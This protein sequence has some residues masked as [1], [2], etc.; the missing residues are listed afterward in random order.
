MTRLAVE[1][2]PPHLSIRT[3]DAAG[4][5][6]GEGEFVMYWMRT[7][8]RG[9][10]NP[11]LDVALEAARRLGLPV[12][13][14][15]ALSERYPYASDRHHRFILAGARDVQAEMAERGIGYAFHL[16]R[17]G[18]RGPH[19]LTLAAR[20]AL[21]VTE[22]MPVAPLRDW[23]EK[24]AEYDPVWAVDAA[25]LAPMRQVEAKATLRAFK[26][27]KASEGMRREWLRAPWPDARPG[28]PAFVPD[29]LPFEPLDLQPGGA[30]GDLAALIATCD[31]DH[32][33]GPVPH[34]PGGSAAGY[35]RWEAFKADGLVRYAW[36]RNDALKPGV[37]RMSAY[38]HYGHVSPFRIA[39]EAAAVGGKGGD[40]YLDELLVW[41]ELAYA[42]CAA[43]PEHDTVGALPD[44][45]RQTLR[46]REGDRRE[47]KSWETLARGR[48][49]DALWDAA[50][51]SLLVHGELHNN[52]RMTWGKALPGWTRNAEEALER[53]IDLNHRY[54]LD[55][56]DPGSFG[57][58]LWCLGQFDRPFDPEQKVLGTVRGR[59][60]RT[61]AKRLDVR[62]YSRRTGAPAWA[63]APSV[64]VI[65]AGLAG[66][67]A[68][69]VLSD[70]GLNV[71]VYDKGRRPGGRANTREHDEHRFD[72]GAQYFTTRDRSMRKYLRSW[73]EDGVVAEWTGELVRLS[74][75]GPA[76][77]GTAGP[78]GEAGSPADSPE[79]TRLLS[80]PASPGPRYVGTPGMISL[81]EHLAADLQ[82]ESGR[83]I[84]AVERQGD[85][86]RLVDADGREA[87]TVDRVLVAVPAPQAAPLLAAAPELQARAA[88]VRMSPCWAGMFTFPGPINPGFDGAFVTSGTFS[89]VARDTSKPG[90][91]GGESWVVHATPEWTGAHLDLDREEAARR[92]LAEFRR[93]IS[94][95]TGMPEEVVPEPTFS[96]AHRWGYALAAEPLGTRCLWDGELGI[97]A[98]G[99]WCH[100]GRVEG[101]LLSGMAMAGRVLGQAP[102]RPGNPLGE[103]GPAPQMSLELG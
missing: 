6:V 63:E 27:R 47:L 16:E 86:W 78:G 62:E 37:S 21:V 77:G 55:G 12:F 32:G 34:T 59:S 25:C 54:A 43:H 7:S 38:L 99:D 100:G 102:A 1:D 65:G 66:L 98:C 22:D 94:A 60:T 71:R 23:T 57:G 90:R 2:L 58:I 89:W 29:D 28:G 103:P 81:A 75:A 56:R 8:V 9:H 45:A 96:R 68:A 53:L 33:V 41:R 49:G 50:Q 67:M 24:L 88:A 91:P 70:H 92:L 76:G 11:A 20:A 19:L 15:H 72:H 82:V 18:H 79:R 26:F 42:F 85:R 64:A 97:G 30:H 48:S 31:I 14:Y 40:K 39:R 83:R 101:A 13:V 69:R 93:F 80:E 4:V 5:E 61:H 87:A 46:E 36:E 17:E 74:E 51:R 52:V 3:R 35:A 44:W 84:E 95:A 73:L 10:E